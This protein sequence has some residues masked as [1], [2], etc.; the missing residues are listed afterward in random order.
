MSTWHIPVDVDLDHL[1]EVMLGLSTINSLSTP[2]LFVLN[3]MKGSHYPQ[4]TLK[5]WG[6]VL[7]LLEDGVS[8]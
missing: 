6:V 4:P 8:S 5:E 3:S 1:D 7:D 2:P